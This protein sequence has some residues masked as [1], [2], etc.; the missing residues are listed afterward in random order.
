[1]KLTEFKLFR[2]SI[3]LK[4]PVTLSRITL[5]KREGLIIQIRIESGES[6]F[7]EIA[8]LPGFS[9]ESLSEAESELRIC[10][11]SQVNGSSID[12]LEKYIVQLFPSVRFGLECALLELKAK[13]EQKRVS[14]LFSNSSRQFVSVNGLLTGRRSEILSKAADYIRKGYKTVKL[15]VGSDDVEL[16]I[17]LTRQVRDAIGDKVLLR[18]DA[19]RRWNLENAQK[20]CRG[21]VECDIEYLEEPLSDSKTLARVL[22][23][24]AFSI[25]IALDET[26]REISPDKLSE[27]KGIKAVV[28]KPTMLGLGQTLEFVQSAQSEGITPVIG[29]S[30]E[31][32]LG[33]T[34]LAQLAAVVNQEDISAGLDTYSWFADD[35]IKGS[36]PVENGI[37]DISKLSSIESVLR[38][39]R[40][41]EV[42][43]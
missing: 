33:L 36:L 11:L 13:R 29:S 19:N 10:L 16:D 4:T 35:I 24:E 26:T 42:V 30:F 37:I 22:S 20:F 41:E 3:P 34:F 6:G 32:G 31:S 7:G 40:L 8:P 12:E 17:V 39:E 1:M 27:F 2:Y 15:K 25:P 28:L 14:I 18:L 38:Y 9:R 5:Y 21:V 43:L 23:N